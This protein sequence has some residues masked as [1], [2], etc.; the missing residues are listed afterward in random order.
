MLMPD[1]ESPV[2]ALN[3]QGQSVKSRNAP[4]M[5]IGQID[6]T[7]YAG[8][9]TRVPIN[10]TTG[11]WATKN[12]TFSIRGQRMHEGGDLIF[13]NPHRSSLVTFHNQQ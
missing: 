12:V 3:F 1:L 11:L 8:K 10:S 6:H 2:F 7:K 9:L 5:E 4:T 13:G